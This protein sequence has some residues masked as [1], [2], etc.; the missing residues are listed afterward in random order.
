MIF[1]NQY[2]LYS[3]SLIISRPRHA[4]IQARQPDKPCLLLLVIIFRHECHNIRPHQILMLL[5]IDDSLL[6]ILQNLNTFRVIQT[7]DHSE[8]QIRLSADA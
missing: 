5:Q 6:H 2:E 3:I 1:F 7:P 8:G 4:L